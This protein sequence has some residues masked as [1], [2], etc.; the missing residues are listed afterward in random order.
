MVLIVAGHVASV[1]IAH[2]EALRLF[3]SVR[4]ALRSQLPLLLLMVAFTVS[5]LWIL[6][7]PF[8]PGI[9]LQGL[10]A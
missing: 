2:V 7:Q 10:S 8:S 3:G 5:G 1:W 6:A 9:S 4:L